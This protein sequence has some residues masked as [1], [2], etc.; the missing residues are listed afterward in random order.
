MERPMPS[1][2]MGCEQGRQSGHL[3]P[4]SELH[5]TGRVPAQGLSQ[6][7]F[8]PKLSLKDAAGYVT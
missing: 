4:P 2:Q 6:Q 8:W 5:R 7:F 1:K 3:Q